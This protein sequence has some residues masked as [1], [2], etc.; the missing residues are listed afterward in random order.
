MTYSGSPYE[1]AEKLFFSRPRPGTFQK[2]AVHS[3]IIVISPGATATT[4]RRLGSAPA[5]ALPSRLAQA[6][7]K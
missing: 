5:L 4:L 2:R 6:H 7:L 3:D 1:S